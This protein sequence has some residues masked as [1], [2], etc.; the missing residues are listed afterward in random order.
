MEMNSWISLFISF[1]LFFVKV[2]SNRN[3]S[4]KVTCPFVFF[5]GQLVE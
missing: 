3:G 4:L 1:L 2:D 5:L